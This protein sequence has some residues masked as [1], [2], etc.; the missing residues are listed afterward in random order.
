MKYGIKEGNHYYAT[1]P[2]TIQ[3][4]RR[5]AGQ[6]FKMARSLKAKLSKKI[7]IV[8]TNDPEH[9]PIGRWKKI[10]ELN[11]VWNEQKGLGYVVWNPVKG[12]KKYAM[13]RDGTIHDLSKLKKL[14]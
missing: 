1:S 9:E 10:G 5:I 12:N 8:G 3:E 13:K 6:G 4:A 14:R 7:T 2:D 11:Y